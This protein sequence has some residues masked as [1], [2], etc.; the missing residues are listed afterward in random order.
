GADIFAAKINI[1]VQWASEAAIAAVERN[2]G[3]ITCAYFDPISLDALIDPMKFF[4][5]GEPIPK[6][7]FPPMEII[8]YYIDPRL[9]GY[10]CDP[11]KLESAKIELSQKYGYKLPD[12]RQDPDYDSLF[13][14]SKDPL[15]VFYGLQPGWVVNMKDSSI[16]K[17]KDEDL[18][19]YYN[20]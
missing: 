9:R 20:S 8:H 5:R 18:V 3:K 12:I 14:P 11:S 6:R 16:L 10:L 17:P 1:E 4:E 2:G 7:S 13:G 15:Q 19:S